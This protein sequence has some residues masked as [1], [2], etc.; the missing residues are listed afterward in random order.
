MIT[1]LN[2]RIRDNLTGENRPILYSLRLWRKSVAFAIAAAKNNVGCMI[3]YE[4]LITNQ[5]EILKKITNYLGIEEFK[6]NA[7]NS[8]ITDQNG[9]QWK[10]NSSFTDQNGISNKTLHGY[11]NNLTKEVIKFIEIFCAPEMRLLGYS[12]STNID[13]LDELVKTYHDPFEIT[14]KKFSKGYSNNRERLKR[15]KERILLLRRG[16]DEVERQRKWFITTE[17]YTAMSSLYDVA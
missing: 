12:K 17:V 2:F 7:F 15:E 9:M 6:G 8:G 3:R 1:S 13:E 10:G 11:K 5:W 14:H 16:V 4:D